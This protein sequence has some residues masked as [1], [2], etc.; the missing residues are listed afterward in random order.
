MT[1]ITA[2]HTPTTIATVF[3]EPAEDASLSSFATP[4][5]HDGVEHG[6]VAVG[7]VAALH[8]EASALAPAEVLQSTVRVWVPVEP[9]VDV[10]QPPHDEEYQL[11]VSHAGA[12]HD[13]EAA[14]FVAATH[15]E[16]SAEM[17]G[18]AREAARAEAA[19]EVGWAAESGVE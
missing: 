9:Q 16:A 14:G 15:L 7:F 2:T 10:E 8:L 6:D 4:K 18:A 3:V 12:E 11:Y 17:E 1:M 19:T 13:V 5:P